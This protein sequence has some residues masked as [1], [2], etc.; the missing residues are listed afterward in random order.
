MTF[1]QCAVSKWIGHSITISGRHYANAVP[2]ELFD[3]AAGDTS[4]GGSAQRQAQRKAPDQTGNGQKPNDNASQ[5]EG[6]N[7]RQ[8]R[9]LRDIS[10]SAGVGRK[11]SRGESNPRA[12][13]VSKPR[14]RV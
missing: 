14:L 3:L 12:E 13:T 2:D 6:A 8:V 1:P 4:G 7:S 10:A 5:P 9:S 11:W